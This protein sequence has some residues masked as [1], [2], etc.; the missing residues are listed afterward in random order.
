M[1]RNS[2]ADIG[3]GGATPDRARFPVEP[4]RQDRH[5]LARMIGAFPGRIAPVVRRDDEKIARPHQ[6]E[7]FGQSCIKGFKRGRIARNIAPMAKFGVEIDEIGE[8]QAAVGKRRKSL[9][10]TVEHS[11]VAGTFQHTACTRVSENI[12]NFS[13][14]DDIASSRCR[15][16]E[17]GR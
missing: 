12:G 10:R 16:F 9:Q 8:E 11:H 4:Q 6:V 14:A 15:S 2:R 1:F 7:Q 3:V 17:N 5:L 13:D